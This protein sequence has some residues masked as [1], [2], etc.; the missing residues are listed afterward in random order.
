MASSSRIEPC[1]IDDTPARIQLGQS[2][3]PIEERA[4]G[5]LPNADGSAFS[6]VNGTPELEQF[7]EWA[8]GR[9]SEVGLDRPRLQS[10]TFGPVPACAG[11]AGAVFDDDVGSPDLVQCSDAYDTCVPRPD[12]CRQFA[13]TARFSLLHELAHVWLIQNVDEPTGESFAATFGLTAWDDRE[14]PWHRRAVEY[15]AEIVA[16][17]TL[18]EVVTLERI[19]DPPCERLAD[20]WEVLTS[21]G[22]PRSC[23]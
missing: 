13:L 3:P 5:E 18:D 19:G 23:G 4:T 22:S 9:F 15:A 20:A 2:P 8:L 17:G 10:V 7:V 21:R 6:V 14:L 1:S 11:R 12:D 16:W